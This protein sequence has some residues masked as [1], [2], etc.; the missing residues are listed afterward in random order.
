MNEMVKWSHTVYSAS[1]GQNF[2]RFYAALRTGL[3][4]GLIKTFFIFYFVYFECTA[5]AKIGSNIMWRVEAS[6]NM[7]KCFTEPPSFAQDMLGFLVGVTAC[8]NRNWKMNSTQIEKLMWEK[9]S[10]WVYELSPITKKVQPD[11]FNG[12]TQARLHATH[13]E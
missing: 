4:L 9:Y 11:R 13:T 1:N 10:E 3:S 7:E 5:P 2:T 6:G 12:R 8:N